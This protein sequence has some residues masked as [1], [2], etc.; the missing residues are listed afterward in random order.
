[1]VGDENLLEHTRR[2]TAELRLSNELLIARENLRQAQEQRAA[3]ELEVLNS[4]DHAIGRAAEIGELRYRLVK[5]AAL[6][7]QRQALARAEFA[8]HDANHRAHIARLE[9]AVAEV[10]R[11]AARAETLEREVATLRSSSTWRLGRMLMS[12]V[13]AVKRL[14][15]RA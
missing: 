5:Q 1:V 3:F 15:R 7:E 4:R 8:V 13:R 11:R 14:L 10:G 9:A 6:Y 2:E 12:P